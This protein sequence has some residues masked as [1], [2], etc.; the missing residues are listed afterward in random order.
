[1]PSFI[2][3]LAIK[4]LWMLFFLLLLATGVKRERFLL[5]EKEKEI[6]RQLA[7]ALF[8]AKLS[9]RIQMA[10]LHQNRQQSDEAKTKQKQKRF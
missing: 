10:T 7:F 2:V 3:T 5:L 6:E 4:P 9:Q 8:S 1:M